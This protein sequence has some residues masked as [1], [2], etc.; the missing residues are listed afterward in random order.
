MLLSKSKSHSLLIW[1]AII[2]LSLITT[3]L[4][5]FDTDRP[6]CYLGLFFLPL[7]F[8]ML[9]FTFFCLYRKMSENVALSLILSLL[10]CRMVLSPLAMYIGNYQATISYNIEKNT[11]GAIILLLY[12]ALAVFLTLF[13]KS[14]REPNIN[15]VQPSVKYTKVTTT[16]KILLLFVTLAFLACICITPQIMDIYRTVFEISDEFFSNYEDSQV[17]SKYATSFISKFS[18]VTGIYLSRLLLLLLPAFFITQL[19][20]KPNKIRKLLAKLLCLTPMF[21]ISG[22]IAMSLIYSICL[23][24]LY[25]YMFSP[26]K[27][28]KKTTT[29][30]AIGAIVTI[31]WWIYKGK[32]ANLFEQFSKRLSAYFSGL[33]VVSGVFNLPRNIDNR[34]RYFLYDFTSTFP[35]GNTIFRISG[36]TVQPF[37]N[38]YNYSFGQI[39]PTIGM[40]YYYFGALL[41]PIYS[42][43]FTNIAY[44]AGYRLSKCLKQNPMQCIRYLITVFYFSMGIVMYNIEITMIH[45]FVPILPMM[46]LEKI[47]YSKEK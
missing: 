33:N 6:E 41:A 13:L 24:F 10:F 21:F 38:K 28:Q 34:I 15:V 31:L 29:L 20:N 45:F 17:V 27:I 40:G 35:Y 5:L 25:T 3:I 7:G 8:G 22:A 47:T 9:S 37:F 30:L 42:I 4:I 1:G 16:Y 36:D 43:A 2:A 19:S 11:S 14:N 12:E 18:M 32:D 44:D 26:R 23:M 46:L 39:P